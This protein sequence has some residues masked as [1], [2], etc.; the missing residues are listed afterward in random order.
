MFRLQLHVTNN[1]PGARVKF[2]PEDLEAMARWVALRFRWP[3][4]AALID[5]DPSLLKNLDQAVNNE[6]DPSEK[7]MQWVG[8]ENLKGLLTTER[9]G[10]R[11]T[12]VPSDTFLRIV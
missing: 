10:A 7:I 11:I 4:L 9:V 12:D 2:Y 3:D 6:A 1:T 5:K 8:D